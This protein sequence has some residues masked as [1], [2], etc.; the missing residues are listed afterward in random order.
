MNRIKRD[1][2]DKDD[3]NI[4]TVTQLRG[5]IKK[6]IKEGREAQL[7]KRGSEGNVRQPPKRKLTESDLR[8]HQEDTKSSMNRRTSLRAVFKVAGLKALGKIA[9]ENNWLEVHTGNVKIV[10]F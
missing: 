8:R 7:E 3:K 6:A 9:F 10:H 2:L 4:D 5:L 1:T